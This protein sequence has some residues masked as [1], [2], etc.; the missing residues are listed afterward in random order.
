MF[1]AFIV[2]L[3]T[4]AGTFMLLDYVYRHHRLFQITNVYLYWIVLIL[5]QDFLYW[6]LHYTGHYVRFFWAMHVTHHSSEKMNFSVS[7]RTSWMGHIKYVFFIPVP[8]LGFD[9]ITFF[10]AHQAAVLYQFFVHTELVKKLP[11]AIEYV[12]VTPSHHR[13]HHGSNAKYIDK[14]Y[15]S[16]FIIWDRMFGTF[17]PEEEKPVYGLTKP[18]KSYNPV[19]LVFHEWVDIGRDLK[20]A[21][22]L[23]EMFNILFKPPGAV[24]TEH[25]RLSLQQEQ[26]AQEVK[27]DRKSVV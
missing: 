11:A 17:V 13:V 3:A 8:L 6:V 10:V 2:N 22:S 14:N 5:V 20:H 1:A 18:V 7:F 16:T 4:K 19:Y 12:F 23:S 26:A 25:Q 27:E 21:K 9:P 24:V 15:G